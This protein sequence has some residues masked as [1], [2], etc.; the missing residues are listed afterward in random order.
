LLSIH[1]TA[2][3]FRQHHVNSIR[4]PELRGDGQS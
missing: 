2:A 3:L 1:A 4:V